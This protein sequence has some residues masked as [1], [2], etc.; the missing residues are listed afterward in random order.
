[1]SE[2]KEDIIKFK[3]S[4]ES[5]WDK[6]T[7][8]SATAHKNTWEEEC[9]ALEDLIGKAEANVKSERKKGDYLSEELTNFVMRGLKR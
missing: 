4:K 2:I 6:L 8:S 3:M 1:V 5:I 9:L 7:L